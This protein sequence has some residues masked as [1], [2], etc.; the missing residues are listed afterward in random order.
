MAS[1]YRLFQMRFFDSGLVCR[2][3]RNVGCKIVGQSK[4]SNGKWFN[5]L[6]DHETHVKVPKLAK[7]PES[8]EH[9]PFSNALNGC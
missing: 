5:F 1:F 7:V 6:Y 3:Y 9:T 8:I 2:I 4:T